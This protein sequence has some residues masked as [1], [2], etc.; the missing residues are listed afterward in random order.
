MAAV[1]DA[2]TRT[3]AGLPVRIQ[4]HQP[5]HERH[6]KLQVHR[7]SAGDYRPQ[8]HVVA[9][10]QHPRVAACKCERFQRID[11]G[12]LRRFVYDHETDV[13]FLAD[14]QLLGALASVCQR[15][16]QLRARA[17]GRN[18]DAAGTNGG[19]GWHGE[20]VER[21]SKVFRG[22]NVDIITQ[23]WTQGVDAAPRAAHQQHVVG[24]EMIAQAEC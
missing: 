17:A 9:S 23:A 13:Q 16:K 14:V 8:L 18:Y 20:G 22:Y 10:E 2:E 19:G 12:G 11:F 21:N 24:G 4:R 15:H 6:V 3:H 5:L 1:V 7:A